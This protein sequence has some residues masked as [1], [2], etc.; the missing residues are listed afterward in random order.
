MKYNIRGDKLEVTDAIKGYVETKL[1][2][3][4]KYFKNDLIYITKLI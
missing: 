4:E 1:D 3:L 2:R